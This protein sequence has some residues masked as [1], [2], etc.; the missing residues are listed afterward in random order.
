MYSEHFPTYCFDDEVNLVSGSL[1][2][3]PPKKLCKEHDHDN[4]VNEEAPSEDSDTEDEGR[5]FNSLF[6]E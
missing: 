6:S 4:G 1:P 5:F 2:T 3:F